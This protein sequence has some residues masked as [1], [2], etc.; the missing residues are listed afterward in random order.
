MHLTATASGEA[1]QML[2]MA[3]SKWGLGREA[4]ATS[5]VLRVPKMG[6]ETATQVQET[7]SPKHGK[8]KVKHPQVHTNQPNKN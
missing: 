6:K 3:R 7:Q 8:S 5:L 2:V 1:A 4:W